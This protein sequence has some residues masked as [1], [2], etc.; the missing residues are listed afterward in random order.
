MW[1]RSIKDTVYSAQQRRP[2]FIME[3]NYNTN[4]WQ[5][6]EIFFRLTPTKMGIKN[7]SKLPKN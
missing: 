3:R 6:L 5:S 7:F 4:S 1:R 2:V